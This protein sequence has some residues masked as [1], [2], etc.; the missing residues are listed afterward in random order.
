MIYLNKTPRDFDGNVSPCF[1]VMARFTHPDSSVTRIRMRYPYDHGKYMLFPLDQEVHIELHE[2]FM[3][4]SLSSISD[5]IA[6]DDF[7]NDYGVVTLTFVPIKEKHY[8]EYCNQ[9]LN[10]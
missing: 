5:F 9:F 6:E 2:N 8:K 4:R 10:S 7:G 3:K 1:P